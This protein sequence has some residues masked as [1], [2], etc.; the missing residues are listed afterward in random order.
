MWLREQLDESPAGQRSTCL[1][2]GRMSPCSWN[3]MA[4]P[5]V[6]PET[7]FLRSLVDQALLQLD[8]PSLDIL[9]P[10]FTK[11]R[12]I[13]VPQLLCRLKTKLTQTLCPAW[14]SGDQSGHWLALKT[15][16]PVWVGVEWIISLLPAL[17]SSCDLG[18]VGRGLGVFL[19]C[20]GVVQRAR[21]SGRRE[22]LVQNWRQLLPPWRSAGTRQG[23]VPRLTCHW[24]GRAGWASSRGQTINAGLVATEP[25]E[26]QNGGQRVPDPLPGGGG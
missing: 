6:S 8:I 4:R 7:P 23:R 11:G 22:R 26:W 13:L 2:V 20:H 5:A 25:G 12:P 3:R 21:S 24:A 10:S 15:F 16:F 14:S 19:S 17:L 9:I 1:H 18:Y